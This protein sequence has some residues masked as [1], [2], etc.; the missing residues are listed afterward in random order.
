MLIK[1]EKNRV[2]W[3]CLHCKIKV[4]KW[5]LRKLNCLSWKSWQVLFFKL[6]SFNIHYAWFSLF[7]QP[8]E[9]TLFVVRYLKRLPG[10]IPNRALL[11]TF[12]LDDAYQ[13]RAAGKFFVM[14]QINAK[15]F[16]Q[17]TDL[18]LSKTVKISLKML[19]FFGIFWQKVH[20]RIFDLKAQIIFFLDFWKRVSGRHLKLS[21]SNKNS[22]FKW[23]EINQ[24]NDRIK[25]HIN[26]VETNT[27]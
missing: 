14:S 18:I 10:S 15:K 6:C 8:I 13:Q 12:L 27:I 23:S 5:F 3:W 16:N 21:I 26:E 4:L 22:T 2:F 11:G 20:T 24:H 19:S 25:T 17:A 7:K 1:F 9:I